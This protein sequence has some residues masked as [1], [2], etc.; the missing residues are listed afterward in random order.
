MFA[1]CFL[2]FWV[3]RPQLV[4]GTNWG[5]FPTVSFRSCSFGICYGTCGWCKLPPMTSRY[6]QEEARIWNYRIEKKLWEI[7]LS[8]YQLKVQKARCEHHF[9]FTAECIFRKLT[10]HGLR[11][12]HEPQA[13]LQSWKL[14]K[15][16][17]SRIRELEMDFLQLLNNHYMETI[18]ELTTE[19]YRMEDEEGKLK[20]DVPLKKIPDGTHRQH[21]KKAERKLTTFQ[22]ELD[23]KRKRKIA[24]LKMET[25]PSRPK[26]TQTQSLFPPK[27][28]PNPGYDSYQGRPK[29][30]QRPKTPPWIHHQGNAHYHDRRQGSIS[31]QGNH[32]TR[33]E[34]HLQIE[35]YHT[36]SK[37]HFH[38][39][40]QHGQTIRHKYS[41][42]E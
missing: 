38:S 35:V 8:Y 39:S 5:L 28:G 32:H 30:Y 27:R 7:G 9:A 17:N 24:A 3:G 12:L 4:P 37:S 18:T 16:W 2:H 11:I 36:Q 14:E 15:E 25:S 29:T 10:P 33:N 22:E 23:K 31:V 20:A 26:P 40:G 6:P 41:V 21:E 19:L 34:P 42:R 13:F 1:S